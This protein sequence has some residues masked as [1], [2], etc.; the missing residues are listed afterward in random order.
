MCS[1][2]FD[3]LPLPLLSG[4]HLVYEL[5]G[6]IFVWGDDCQRFVTLVVNGFLRLRKVNTYLLVDCLHELN[7]GGH[8]VLSLLLERVLLVLV[9][10]E[11]LFEESFVDLGLDPLDFDL[12]GLP[13]GFLV[14]EGD[15]VT[16]ED[17]LLQLFPP[18]GHD[19]VEDE[20]DALVLGQFGHVL[21]DLHGA[22]HVHVGDGDVTQVNLLLGFCQTEC[23]TVE[24]EASVLN[25]VASVKHGF[26]LAA[27]YVNVVNTL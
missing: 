14:L 8:T 16:V 1:L 3:L 9:H 7:V 10:V 21:L 19:G 18:V 20:G 12:V 11:Y 4:F 26:I 6:D 23:L 15:E 5:F 24:S 13:S 22:F 27:G 17:V 25:E 2:H